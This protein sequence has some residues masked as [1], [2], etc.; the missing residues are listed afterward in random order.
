[1]LFAFSCLVQSRAYSS[2]QIAILCLKAY[3]IPS[4]DS[5]SSA[6]CVHA[7]NMNSKCTLSFLF[8][9]YASY[10]GSSALLLSQTLSR[11]WMVALVV[12]FRISQCAARGIRC[13]FARS[14]S[15]QVSHLRVA[16][17]HTTLP[18][19]VSARRTLSSKSNRI[20]CSNCWAA[21]DFLER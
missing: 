17:K 20:I 16:C 8:A 13:V 1:M 19:T 2:N 9:H 12:R 15:G 14:P 4:F 3:H 6:S 11:H 10:R 7:A 18:A 21:E 5:H